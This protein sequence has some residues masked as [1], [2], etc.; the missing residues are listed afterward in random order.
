MIP[1]LFLSFLTVDIFEYSQRDLIVTSVSAEDRDSGQ[2]GIFTYA[3][4]SG[5]TNGAFRI[6][7][8]TGKSYT[9]YFMLSSKVF[10][11]LTMWKTALVVQCENKIRKRL[12]TVSNAALDTEITAVTVNINMQEL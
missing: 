10:H 8:A 9:K 1:S 11:V 4:V 7:P 12:E 2:Y 5:N 3:I 6:N